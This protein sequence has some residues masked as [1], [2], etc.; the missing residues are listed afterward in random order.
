MGKQTEKSIRILIAEDH[1]IARCGLKT[2]LDQQRDFDVI[3]EVSSCEETLNLISSLSPDVTL[4]NLTLNDG[5]S[6][7]CIVKFKDLCPNCKVLIY[8]ASTNKE[9]HLLAIRYGAVG[10][11]LKSQKAELVCKAIRNVHLNDELWIDKTLTTQMWKQHMQS[12]IE[13]DIKESSSPSS[14]STTTDKSNSASSIC[15]QNT[16][17]PRENQIACF[18]SK[19]LTAK[20]IGEKLFISEKTVRNQLTIIYSKLNVKNQLELTI[21]CSNCNFLDICTK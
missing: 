6:L 10:I 16:L 17:T 5:G 7:D 15:H 8:T 21:N 19:G 14:S 3:G 4:L 9:I 12:T 18:S 1:E 11:L 13:S 2:I 20:Q